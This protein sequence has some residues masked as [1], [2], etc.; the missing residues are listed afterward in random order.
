MVIRRAVPVHLARIW[1]V[2]PSQI[3]LAWITLTKQDIKARVGRLTYD[4]LA[5]S[6]LES[7]GP[8][9]SASARSSRPL[10]IACVVF[11]LTALVAARAIVQ[12]E[13]DRLQHE[14]TLISGAAK[15]HAQLLEAHV[16]RALSANYALAALVRCT[17]SRTYTGRRGAPHPNRITDGSPFV[18]AGPIPNQ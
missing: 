11:V 2:A 9:R 13:R 3:N 12:L 18:R 1:C 5:G 7:S 17:G 14:R 16:E 4:Q 8:P 6:P 15:D 10:I